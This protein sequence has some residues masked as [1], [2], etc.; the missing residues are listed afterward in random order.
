MAI[1]HRCSNTSLQLQFVFS[2]N[3]CFKAYFNAGGQTNKHLACD[4]SSHLLHLESR[5]CL[6]QSILLHEI[7][8]N[9]SFPCECVFLKAGE[10]ASK[11]IK[12]KNKPMSKKKLWLK[13][14]KSRSHVRLVTP[15]FSYTSTPYHP[16][17]SCFQLL[18]TAT[19]QLFLL[20]LYQS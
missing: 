2:L 10:V 14:F 18:T 5:D 15:R 17:T 6:K 9:A 7:L 1:W 13:V 16:T 11:K 20:Y 4:V 19:M 3:H 8:C 12:N